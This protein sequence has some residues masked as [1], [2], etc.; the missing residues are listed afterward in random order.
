MG[1]VYPTWVEAAEILVG[2]F[3]GETG[4]HFVGTVIFV[5]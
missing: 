3:I 2:N 1:H 4:R 5:Q